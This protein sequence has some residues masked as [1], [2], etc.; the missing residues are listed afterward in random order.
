MAAME[1]L[2]YLITNGCT[3]ASYIEFSNKNITTRR[4]TRNCAWGEYNTK[5]GNGFLS[6]SIATASSSL[7]VRDSGRSGGGGGGGGWDASCMVQGGH[8]LLAIR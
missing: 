1:R 8:Q 5:F 3:L 2:G 6:I 4:P 7:P